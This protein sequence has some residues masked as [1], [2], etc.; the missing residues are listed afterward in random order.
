MRDKCIFK[1]VDGERIPVAA[2]CIFHFNCG[3]YQLKTMQ[4]FMP[5]PIMTAILGASLVFLS[6]LNRAVI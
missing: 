3:Y 1:P 2:I 5:S 4:K 6:Y